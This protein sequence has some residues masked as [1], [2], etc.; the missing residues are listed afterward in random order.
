LSTLSDEQVTGT[1]AKR[2]ATNAARLS[3]QLRGDLDWIVMR[4]LEKDRTRRYASAHDLATDLQRYLHNEPI[5][6]RPPSFF[7]TL[8]KF[9]RRHRLIFASTALI[10]AI[11]IIATLVSTTMAI[12]A[13]HAEQVALR[14]KQ[15]AQQERHGAEKVSN[16]M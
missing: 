1:V 15:Q 4:C 6:A 3:K 7:Y 5:N 10:F 11:L 14:A 8:S 16:F 12:R 13:T 9:A 2:H